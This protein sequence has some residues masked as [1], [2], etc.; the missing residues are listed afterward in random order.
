MGKARGTPMRAA[1]FE[2]IGAYPEPLLLLHIIFSTT[3]AVE[4]WLL[5]FDGDFVDLALIGAVMA[6]ERLHLIR[7]L[8]ELE[9]LEAAA[10]TGVF[11]HRQ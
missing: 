11:V 10:L 7:K 1:L 6:G 8:G 3:A 4:Q 9:A 5:P 2:Q